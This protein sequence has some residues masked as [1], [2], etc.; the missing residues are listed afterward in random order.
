M[1]LQLTLDK[2]NCLG[3][4]EIVRVEMKVRDNESFFH[5]TSNLGTEEFVW[6]MGKFGLRSIRLAGPGHLDH[7]LSKTVC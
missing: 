3:T 4:E 2:S 6:A 1:S 5:E 7:N